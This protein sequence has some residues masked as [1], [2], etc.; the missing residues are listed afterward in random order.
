MLEQ[1][2]RS[3]WLQG[4]KPT[5]EPVVSPQHAWR[6]FQLA[7]IL[8]C[9]KG[10]VVAKDNERRLTDLLWFPTGGGKTEAYLGLIAFTAFLRR[11]RGRDGAGVTALM[12]Y[13]LRLLTI[14]QF[15]R[16]ALLICAC[17][18][19]RRTHTRLG[20]RPFSIGLWVGEAATPNDHTQTRKSLDALHN[21]RQLAEANPMQLQACPWCGTRFDHR[22]LLAS[23][24]QAA[25]TR[26]QLSHGRMRVSGRI[27]RIRR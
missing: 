24:D 3:E 27:A 20:T 10:V 21:N 6:P 19:I 26:H 16:A 5:P 25:A 2:A 15:E 1:R 23:A 8:L 13:T 18:S 12:R 7:F 22:E 17:E 11:L 14:Q 9:L 4:D